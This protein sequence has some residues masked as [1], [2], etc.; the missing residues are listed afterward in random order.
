M[1][2]QLNLPMFPY[3]DCPMERWSCVFVASCTR[4]GRC[5]AYG[6]TGI[7]PW[8][9]SSKASGA[10]GET[11]GGGAIRRQPPSKHRRPKPESQRE[12]SVE[13]P[14]CTKKKRRVK[15]KAAKRRRQSK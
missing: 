6:P 14:R 10:D 4:V 5:N 3:P 1:G 2:T 9:Y 11:E 15:K 7:A 12:E 8:M 13:P